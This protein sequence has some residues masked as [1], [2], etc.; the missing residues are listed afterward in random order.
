MYLFKTENVYIVS[1]VLMMMVA[2]SSWISMREL[3]IKNIRIYRNILVSVMI[4]GGLTLVLVVKGVLGLEPWYV[5][6][7]IIP[8]ASMIFAN[9]MNTLS[10][11]AERHEAELNRGA[12]YVEARNIAYK[13]A[14]IPITNSM[15]AV[16]LVSLPGMMTGQILSGVSPLIAARYQIMVMSMLYGSSGLSAALYLFFA[17]K[18]LVKS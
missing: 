7:H 13:T 6:D 4:G 12:E 5:P 14:L 16:G 15:F 1:L 8:L 2:V 18:S 3:M 9:A 17:R 10:L 11:A